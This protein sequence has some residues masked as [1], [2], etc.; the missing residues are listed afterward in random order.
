VTQTVA[1]GLAMRLACPLTRPLRESPGTDGT[2][3][4]GLYAVPSYQLPK[5]V[6]CGGD[7]SVILLSMSGTLAT[8]I[9][10]VASAGAACR[11]TARSPCARRCGR[12]AYSLIEW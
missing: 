2:R 4:R 8:D 7:S 5:Q 3:P 11:S 1:T 12:A 10:V 6:P 9:G